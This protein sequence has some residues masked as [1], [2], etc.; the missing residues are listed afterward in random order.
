MAGMEDDL[1]ARPLRIGRKEQ[2][3]PL[4]TLYLDDGTDKGYLVGA[5]PLDLSLE[6]CS[7][8]T[9]LD[10]DQ[11]EGLLYAMAVGQQAIVS[12]IR[13]HIG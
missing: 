12:E 2:I 7:R 8:W 10:R 13:I 4:R 9:R 11:R 5:L 3:S 6:L 1:L